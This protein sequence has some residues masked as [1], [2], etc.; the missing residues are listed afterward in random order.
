[1]SKHTGLGMASLLMIVFCL[2]LVCFSLLSLSSASHS[3]TLAKD[4][5]EYMVL[6][7]EAQS[8]IQQQIS[9]LTSP[10]KTVLSAPINEEHILQAEV[11]N[12]KILSLKIIHSNTWQ[13]DQSVNLWN[14]EDE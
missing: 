3:Y 4:S 8:D 12:Y 10:Q 9:N 11:E 6:N 7:Y 14:G 2:A 1:M 5:L 13:P